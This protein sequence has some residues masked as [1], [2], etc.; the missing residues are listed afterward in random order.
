[1]PS[2]LWAGIG[3]E[4]AR[5]RGLAPEELPAFYRQRNLLRT[6][7]TGS[8][9]GHAV[10][11]AAVG[12]VP[13][14]AGSWQACAVDRAGNAACS[15]AVAFEIPEPPPPPDSGVDPGGDT[16]AA[17]PTPDPGEKPPTEESGCGCAGGPS[18]APSLG[19]IALAFALVVRRR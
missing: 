3:P 19:V 10:F 11:R 5:A 16:G 8:H 9:V 2:G 12:S 7:V 18:G 4:R 6:E 17:P 15:A 13:P 14:G 1:V